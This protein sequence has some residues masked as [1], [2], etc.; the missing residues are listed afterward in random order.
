MGED[1]RLLSV[2]AS[3]PDFKQIRRVYF[4][5][6]ILPYAA[7]FFICC[8]S[9]LPQLSLN[10]VICASKQR[11]THAWTHPL[12]RPQ[13]RPSASSGKTPKASF[14]WW[15]VRTKASSKPIHLP[16][17]AHHAICQSV[18]PSGDNDILRVDGGGREALLK[19][20]NRY[21]LVQVD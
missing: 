15:R 18:R 12:S 20:G 5:L 13:K 14:Y 19:I 1:G 7:F 9:F 11:E 4:Y 3:H 8:A 21:M 17:T 10:L 16:H 2:A 6:K